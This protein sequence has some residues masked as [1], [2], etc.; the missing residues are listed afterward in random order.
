VDDVAAKNP[1]TYGDFEQRFLR[2]QPQLDPVLDALVEVLMQMWGQYDA[3]A[4]NSIITASFDFVTTSCMEPDL[5]KAPLVKGTQR[6]SYYLRERTGGSYAYAFLLFPKSSQISVTEYIQA[7][8]DMCF[9]ISMVND[10]ISSVSCLVPFHPI[11]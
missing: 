9:W 1:A 11:F 10:L 3:L 7:M 2:G 5:E 8:P 6:F 4:A